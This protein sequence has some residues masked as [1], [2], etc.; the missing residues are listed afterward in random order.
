MIELQ[1]TYRYSAVG[2]DWLEMI[3]QCYCAPLTD[4]RSIDFVR[5]I[6]DEDRTIRKSLRKLLDK[7]R[8]A[9]ENG[10]ALAAVKH[11]QAYE[12][13]W[14]EYFTIASENGPLTTGGS[15]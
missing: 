12:R 2:Q 15:Q 13:L 3:E 6:E 8:R 9:Q 11:L 10:H 14:H 7:S 1:T 4:Q 5:Y